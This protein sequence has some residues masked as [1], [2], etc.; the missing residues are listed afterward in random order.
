MSKVVRYCRRPQ[1]HTA[2]LVDVRKDGTV[3]EICPFC[4]INEWILGVSEMLWGPEAA[5]IGVA[6]EPLEK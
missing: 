1:S 4:L 2:M 3:L 6:N 5:G